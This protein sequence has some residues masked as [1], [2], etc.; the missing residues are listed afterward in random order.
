MRPFTFRC[1]QMNMHDFNVKNT[2]LIS[3]LSQN[4]FGVCAPAKTARVNLSL[5]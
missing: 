4:E 3:E 1:T 2:L 5:E